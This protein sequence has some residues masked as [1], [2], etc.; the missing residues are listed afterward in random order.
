M[1]KKKKALFFILTL[2]GLAIAIPK[3]KI[4]QKLFIVKQIATIN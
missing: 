1:Q 4:K 2:F 3:K